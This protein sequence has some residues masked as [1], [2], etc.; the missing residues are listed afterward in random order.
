MNAIDFVNAISQIIPNKKDL[1]RNTNV[2]ESLI[3]I[4]IQELQIIKKTSHT[5]ISPLQPVIDLII[6]YDLSR[7]YIQQYHFN[8]EKDLAENN[9]FI[10]IGWVEAFL[11]AIS[12]E[13]GEVVETDW[14]APNH[15]ISF[16]A[17]DQCS[18]LDALVELAK[19][20]QKRLFESLTDN[21]EKNIVKHIQSIAGG[22]KYN[23]DI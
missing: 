11:V 22:N 14:D 6:N 15:I 7:L 16:I 12:K 21:E 23:P 10:Y 17:K 5:D 18:F 20:S 13:T 3:D 1:L 9:Q 4:C 19:L 8:D 2:S